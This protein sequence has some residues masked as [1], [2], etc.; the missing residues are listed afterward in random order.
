M[1]PVVEKIGV[2]DRHNKITPGSQIAPP[3]IQI[4]PLAVTRA[5]TRTG[6]LI[7]P[8]P[9]YLLLVGPSAAVC[10]RYE[11]I[12]PHGSKVSRSKSRPCRAGS[13]FPCA[14]C[15]VGAVQLGSL[16]CFCRCTVAARSLPVQ[17]RQLHL[18]VASSPPCSSSTASQS[19]RGAP[20]GHA[21]PADFHESCM[22]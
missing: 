3:Q 9:T 12:L 13:W 6:E 2:L 4:A 14:E 19:A 11:E 17:E 8:L 15:S 5:V 20:R 16:P 7:E 1:T 21:R 18:I 10:R 22:I